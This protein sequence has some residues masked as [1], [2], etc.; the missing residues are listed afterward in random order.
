MGDHDVSSGVDEAHL[1]A[2]MKA[3]LADVQAL[4]TMLDRG[5]IES[6]VRRIGAEQEMFFVD[7]AGRPATPAI[8]V[9]KRLDHPSFTHELALFNLEANLSPQRFGGSCLRDMEEELQHLVAMVR[10]AAHAENSEIVLT[11]ILPTL[12][13]SDL[14]IE[15]MT[16]NPRYVELNNAMSRA[17]NGRFHFRIKGVDELETTHDNVMLESCN[18][19]FQVHFQVAPKE[20]AKLYNLAQAIS[21]PVLAVAANSPVLLGRRLWHETRCALFQQSVDGRSEAHKARG[22]RPRVSFGTDWVKDSVLEIFKEDIA[23]FRVVIASDLDEDPMAVIER[24]EVPALKA[25]RVHNSTVYRWNRACYGISDGKPHLRIENRILPAGPT[26]LDEMGNAAFFFGLMSGLAEHYDDISDVMSFSHAKENFLAAARL[27]LKASFTWVDQKEVPA[28]TLILDRLLPAARA[29]LRDAGLDQSDIDRYL[30]VVES[31]V[32]K[33]RTGAQWTLD[34]LAAMEGSGNLDQ[35]LRALTLTTIENQKRSVPIH[36]WRLA[37]L[38]D[39]TD[40]RSSYMKV[41]QFMTTDVFTVHPEDLVDLAASL[42]D[43]RHIR[44]VPVEDQ[45]GR[46][47]G[48]VSHRSLLRLVG[49]GV[50]SES[51]GPIA[52]KDIMRANPVC[53][54]PETPTLQAIEVMRE[55]RVGCLPI[56]DKDRLVGIITER[57]LITVASVLFE[58]HL[59][60][61]T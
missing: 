29:G 28:S 49:Q 47:L 56:V 8:E 48:L 51:G 26:I 24:G 54:T 59:R 21:G 42:M 50:G 60:E 6:D 41:G 1:R 9:M 33:S 4:G 52:V 44:H 16:P 14:G 46:L 38:D 27:G 20:F 32:N 17:R 15:N 3:V 13:Q 58:R 12:E 39:K 30:G 45:D 18:T 55:N 34:S 22:L 37:R 10:E 23:R 5:L 35:R 40:W 57:D 61:N 43:W 7:S 31:R 2:F 25:L 11:G 53:V 19:S 36:E